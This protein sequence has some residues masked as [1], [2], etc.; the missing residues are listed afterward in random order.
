VSEPRRQVIMTAG[1]TSNTIDFIV[2]KRTNLTISAPAVQYSDGAT[3]T[4]RLTDSDGTPLAGKTV[5]FSMGCTHATAATDQN[6]VATWQPTIALKSGSYEVKVSFDG[7]DLY[8]GSD[9]S[10][11][12]TVNKESVGVTYTGATRVKKGKSLSMSA[13]LNEQADGSPGDLSKISNVYFEI[14]NSC[15][16]LVKRCSAKV[17]VSSPGVATAQTSATISLSAGTYTLKVVEDEN[18]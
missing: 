13:S 18:D 6:G 4:A 8:V 17:C 11:T 12:L 5:T 10:G 7:D 16:Q 14:Y 1:G 3:I 9:T 2:L 15:G